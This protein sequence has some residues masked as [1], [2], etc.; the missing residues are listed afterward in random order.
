MCVHYRVNT[1]V[2]GVC[3]VKFCEDIPSVVDICLLLVMQEFFLCRYLGSI[4]SCALIFGGVSFIYY[5]VVCP[6]L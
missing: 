5:L 1:L 4:C 2:L 6:C 3:M